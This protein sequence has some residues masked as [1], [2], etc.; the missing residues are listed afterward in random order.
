MGL[1]DVD[2]LARRASSVLSVKASVTCKN[3]KAW[4]LQ[5]K[6]NTPSPSKKK[7]TH[8]AGFEPAR[9][10][11]NRYLD[12]KIQVLRTLLAGWVFQFGRT[13]QAPRVKTKMTN[14]FQI[15]REKKIHISRISRPRPCLPFFQCEFSRLHCSTFRKTARM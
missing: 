3:E 5:N 13:Q 9:G 6:G 2:G 14:E 7:F 8:S 11:P 4:W 10:D 12:F 1:K 15:E